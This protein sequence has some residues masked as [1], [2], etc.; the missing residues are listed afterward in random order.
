MLDYFFTPTAASGDFPVPQEGVSEFKME[1]L[2]FTGRNTCLR[3]TGL[4]AMLVASQVCD[5]EKRGIA[6]L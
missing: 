2:D 3:K 5:R 1:T 6:R 4:A